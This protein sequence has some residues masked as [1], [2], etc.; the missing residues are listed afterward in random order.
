MCKLCLNK[1]YGWIRCDNGIRKLQYCNDCGIF[2]NVADAGQQA[3]SDGMDRATKCAI[4]K[5]RD[6]IWYVNV[7]TK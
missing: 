6:Q 2:S 3:K 5:E 1:C 7:K 4:Q